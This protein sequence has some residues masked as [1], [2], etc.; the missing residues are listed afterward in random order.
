M[1]KRKK[2]MSA[3]M[4]VVILAAVLLG[5]TGMLNGKKT[6]GKNIK[7]GDVKEFYYTYDASTN[8][9]KYQRYRFYAE[10]GKYFFYHE[11]R[12]GDHWPLTETDATVKGTVELTGTQWV[13]FFAL[14]T[15]GTVEKRTE[16][17]ESGN[18]GPWLYLYWS[19]DHGKIQ[20]FSFA[21][22][23]DRAAFRQFC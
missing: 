11:K 12:E 3:V 20:E 16:H 10:G 5:G 19:K 1:Q 13:D 4:I 14:I 15:G 23:E 21:T 17:L 7:I 18:A 22:P 6:V 9:P 8:P 2:L